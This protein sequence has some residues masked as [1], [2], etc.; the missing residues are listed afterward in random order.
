VL[1]LFLNFEFFSRL[2]T[3]NFFCMRVNI[4]FNLKMDISGRCF[5]PILTFHSQP[6]PSIRGQGSSPIVPPS[7]MAVTINL[8]HLAS[9]QFVR[10]EADSQPRKTTPS[11]LWKRSHPFSSLF[12][13]CP[14]KH[15]GR[16]WP[17]GSPFSGK[18]GFG[19][20]GERHRTWG[21]S[22]VIHG[23]RIRGHQGRRAV[24]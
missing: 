16:E 21:L 1:I 8:I 5:F 11:V 7:H 12:P 17:R 22:T 13:K 10:P 14:T 19:L 6:H 15:K 23:R 24:N 3:A 20:P 2:K 4:F 18:G 9:C